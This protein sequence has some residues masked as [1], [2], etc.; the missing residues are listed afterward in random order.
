MKFSASV[1]IALAMGLV[2]SAANTHSCGC[3]S[4]CPQAAFVC[5]SCK[6]D[7]VC[8][9]CLEC[10]NTTSAEVTPPLN[11]RRYAEIRSW[12]A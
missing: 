4:G 7:E 1:L 12:E 6:M 5:W 3:I 8:G 2:A 11:Q 10:K 9:G